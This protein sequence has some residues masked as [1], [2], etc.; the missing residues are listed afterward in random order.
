[1]LEPL[2][3]PFPVIL[4]QVRGGL[5]AGRW[6]VSSSVNGSDEGT[7]RIRWGRTGKAP[8]GGPG[9]GGEC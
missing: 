3:L 6:S 9:L 5:C 8:R 2:V 7:L 4:F 1:M